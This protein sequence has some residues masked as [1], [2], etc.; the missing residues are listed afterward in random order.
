MLQIWQFRGRYRPGRPQAQLVG[1][2]VFQTLDVLIRGELVLLFVF[3]SSLLAHANLVSA[4]TVQCYQGVTELQSV[5]EPS[6]S[7]RL[8]PCTKRIELLLQ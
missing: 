6:R 2:R 8:F 4:L 3:V 7:K 1:S 5:R